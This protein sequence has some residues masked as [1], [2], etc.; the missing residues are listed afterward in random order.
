MEPPT[1][2]DTEAK[3]VI[4]GI[5]KAMVSAFQLN[6]YIDH[7]RLTLKYAFFAERLFTDWLHE[8]KKSSSLLKGR[9]EYLKITPPYVVTH[10]CVVELIFK[11]CKDLKQPADTRY[12]TVELFDRLGKKLC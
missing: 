5:E 9:D 6:H 3:Y 12:R 2:T 1:T 10:S 7:L 4:Y 11:M 8:L